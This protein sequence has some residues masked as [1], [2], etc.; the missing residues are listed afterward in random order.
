MI[1]RIARF[2]FNLLGRYL[3]RYEWHY[4]WDDDAEGNPFVTDEYQTCPFCHKE[5]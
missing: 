5:L 2:F 4:N 1:E 3:M